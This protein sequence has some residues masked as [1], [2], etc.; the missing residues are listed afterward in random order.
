[1]TGGKRPYP[2]RVAHAIKALTTPSQP[3]GRC[4]YV[5]LQ[6]PH[7]LSSPKGVRRVVNGLERVG[8]GQEAVHAEERDRI[9]GDAK[10]GRPVARL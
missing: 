2:M 9:P 6:R 5:P 1:M 10:G 7:P 8:D 4:E 3:M